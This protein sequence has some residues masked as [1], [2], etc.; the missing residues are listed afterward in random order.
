MNMN[1]VLFL[2]Y[3]DILRQR[4]LLIIVVLA[5]TLGITNTVM[6][7]GLMKGFEQYISGDIVETIAGHILITPKEG[8]DYF[9]DPLAIIDKAEAID[10]VKSV[11]PRTYIG[12][13]IFK[14]EG[15]GRETRV[16]IRAGGAASQQVIAMD[17]ERETLSSTIKNKVT[18]GDYL[19]GER[20]QIML[21][22]SMADEIVGVDVGDKVDVSFPNGRKETMDVIGLVETGEQALDMMYAYMNSNDADRI[23]GGKNK[24]NTI[25]VKLY[26]QD[27]ADFVKRELLQSGVD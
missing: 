9:S 20:G 6:T 1:A 23:L 22:R 12:V 14:A 17:P 16:A 15:Y 25:L 26:N 21:G 10:K 24:F 7:V 19:T 8:Q 13:K 11:S 27:D 3:K 4:K 18:K 5:L 2:A